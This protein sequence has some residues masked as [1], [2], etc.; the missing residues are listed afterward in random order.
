MGKNAR[1]SPIQSP[2]MRD[3]ARQM[4]A[5]SPQVSKK[6]NTKKKFCFEKQLEAID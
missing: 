1:M 3:K 4:T 6:G 5:I 2:D